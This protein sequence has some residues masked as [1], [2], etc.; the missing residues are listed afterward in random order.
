MQINYIILTHKNPQQ[1]ER[2]INRL[3]ADNICF[4]IHIDK[5]TNI[6]H[7]KYLEKQNVVLID[8]RIDVV[9]GDFSIVNATLNTMNYITDK[10][11]HRGTPYYLVHKTIL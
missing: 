8:H 10:Q 11:T 2:L 7:F 9:W 4:Y 1:L 6:E 3:D 5:K